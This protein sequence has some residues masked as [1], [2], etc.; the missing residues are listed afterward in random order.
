MGT[1]LR[2]TITRCVSVLLLAA[3]WVFPAPVQAAVVTYDL[4]YVFSPA[5]G[6]VSPM[7]RVTMTDV[8]NFVDFSV[9]NLAGAGTKLDSLYFNFSQGTINPIALTF[10][11]V[12]VNG[13]TLAASNYT[14]LLAATQSTQNA[15]L[16]ADGDGYF[17]GKIAYTTNNFLANGATLTFRLS[18]T[19]VNLDTS[20]FNFMSLPGGGSGSYTLASHIQ[21]LPGAMGYSGNSVWVGN[22]AP[23]PVPAA[24]VLFGTGLVS[25]FGAAKRR[26]VRR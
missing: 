7:A 23:V 18:A 26:L 14:T 16:K 19:G 1:I 6:S 24:A 25:L 21:N 2:A 10:S 5:P 8:G 11:Q 22:P 15:N 17:D 12:A 9:V 13:T 20:N 4:N 3:L